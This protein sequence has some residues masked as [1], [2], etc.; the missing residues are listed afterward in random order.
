VPLIFTATNDEIKKGETTDVYFRRAIDIIRKHGLDKKVKMEVR[1]RKLPQGWEYGVLCGIEETITVLEGIPVNLWCMREGEIFF[2]E[3]PVLVIEGMYSD[4]GVLESPILGF[5]CQ[6]T[7][8]ATK[9]SRC[10]RAAGGKPVISFGVRR[11]HPAIAPGRSRRE[12][13]PIAS[14]SSP[15]IQQRHTSSLTRRCPPR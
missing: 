11:M 13:C 4:F 6:S 3:E 10:K 8:I 2:E 5:L 14:S 15:E 7:G 12:R 9:A 1:A